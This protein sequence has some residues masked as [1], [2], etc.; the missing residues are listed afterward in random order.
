MLLRV[1]NRV[2]FAEEAQRYTVQ[3]AGK[4]YAVLTKPFNARKTTIYTVV[5]V[6][7]GVRGTE[8]LIFTSGAETREQCEEMLARLEGLDPDMDFVTEVSHRNRIPLRV[9]EVLPR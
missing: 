7:E 3:A 8:N 1:D 6:E 4:R 9:Q 2:K 5:D